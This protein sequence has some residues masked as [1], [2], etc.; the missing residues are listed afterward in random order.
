MSAPLALATR[1]HGRVETAQGAEDQKHGGVGR[2][3]V[4]GRRDVEDADV[5]LCAGVDIDL[6]V[7]GA[8][9]YALAHRPKCSQWDHRCHCIT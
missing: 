1:E 7:A 4:D 3:V 9:G 6:V 8:C 2:G 5:V